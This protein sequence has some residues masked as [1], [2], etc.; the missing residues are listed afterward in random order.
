MF[1]S[2]T[3]LQTHNSYDCPFLDQLPH[4][5]PPTAFP[6]PCLSIPPLHITHQHHTVLVL[7]LPGHR[8]KFRDPYRNR[9]CLTSS[10]ISKAI[11]SKTGR[12]TTVYVLI[13]VSKAQTYHYWTLYHILFLGEGGAQE[14][15]YMWWVSLSGLTGYSP[16]ISFIFCFLFHLF[17]SSHPSIQPCSRI[18]RRPRSPTAGCQTRNG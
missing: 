6:K 13:H 18:S 12:H 5:Q 9:S 14:N 1:P 15:M 11:L 3:S 2:L 10:S 16:S 4:Q 17:S 8:V 7:A